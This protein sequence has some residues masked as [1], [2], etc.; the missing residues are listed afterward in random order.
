[1]DRNWKIITDLVLP[2]KT[3][4]EVAEAWGISRERVRQIFKTK[5]GAN[6]PKIR[7]LLSD[8][9]SLFRCVTCGEKLNTVAINRKQNFCSKKC[10]KF[11]VKYDIK[12]PTTCEQCGIKYFPHRNNR[13]YK[14]MRKEKRDFCSM[15][16]YMDSGT[17]QLAGRKSYKANKIT[18]E[19]A[20]CGKEVEVALWKSGTPRKYCSPHCAY[21]YRKKDTFTKKLKKY[22]PSL[23]K[24]IKNQE[25]P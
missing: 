10:G 18:I 13:F 25:A 6:P 22:Y 23:Y 12:N 24:Q 16:C 5:V 8:S 9:S 17:L 2:G 21:E 19:C 15:G 7:S 3:A 14:R 4:T 11:M 20:Y 1:M